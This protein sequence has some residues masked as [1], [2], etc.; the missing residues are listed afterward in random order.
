LRTGGAEPANTRRRQ[1]LEDATLFRLLVDRVL[2]YAIFLLTPDGHIRSWNAGAERLK[3]YTADE[4]IGD[5]FERFYPPEAREAGL[6]RRLLAI[7]ASEGRVENEGWRVRKDGS[8]FWADV[9]ITALFDDAGSLRGFAKVTRDLTERRAAEEQLRRSEERFRT[10]IDSVKDYAIFVLSTD[11]TVLS[12]NQGAQQL[13]GYVPQE[14]IGQSFERFYPPEAREAGLPKRLLAIAA[15]EGRVENEGWRVRKDGS[16]FWADVVITALRDE[17]GELIGYAKVTRDLTDRH[18]AEHDRAARLAAEHAAERIERLQVATAALA[19]ASRPEQAAAVLTDVAARALEATVAAVAVPIEDNARLEVLDVRASRPSILRAHQKLGSDEPYPLTYAW[20]THQMLFLQARDQVASKCPELAPLLTRSAMGAWAA[21]PLAVDGRSLGVLGLAFATTRALNTDERSFLL[22]L[23]E[24]GAQAMDR[25]RLY[26]SERLARTEAEAA[27]RAQD[28]FLSVA[29]HELRTPVAAVKVTAQLAERTMAR[30]RLEPERMAAHLQRIGNA[31][32]RLAA[33]IEDLL[34]VSRLRTGRIR[35]RCEPID[36]RA[37]LD[38]IVGRYIA[39]ETRHRFSLSS[40]ED[41]LIVEADP[42]RVE[43]VIEN[44]LSNAVKYSPNGGTIQ[45]RLA[46]AGDGASLTITDQ[47]IGVPAGQ[48]GRIFEAFGRGSNAADQQIQGLGLGLA[49]CRQLVE[50][51]GGRI[52]ATSPGVDQGTTF[53][54]WLPSVAAVQ[55][56]PASPPG[57]DGAHG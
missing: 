51:H 34:D 52:W 44:L 17:R 24:V 4:I 57:G 40:P 19:A 20:R 12:W 50:V 3:G 25:A 26:A 42:L 53:S 37:L 16:L 41:P 56:D 1:H 18:Q 54:V 48:E 28:E 11:G 31:A 15:A 55:D 43:Q 39:T 7:A 30:G 27:V 10:L 13:K 8:R 38:E 21:I 36:V 47:G 29:A 45:L 22:A 6:P 49:I 23:A 9:V 33:L 35:L 46:R 32:D 2:D 14:I 5:S